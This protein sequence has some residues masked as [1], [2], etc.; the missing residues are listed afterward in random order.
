MENGA[1]TGVISI[2]VTFPAGFV[3]EDLIASLLDEKLIACANLLPEITSLYMWEG[4]M[5]CD[6]E[7]VAILKTSADRAETLTA[8]IRA[9]HPYEVPCIVAWPVIGGFTPYLEWVKT[10]T[11]A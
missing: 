1:E 2:Y 8:R 3:V 6:R 9:A 7:T 5:E 11:Q 4:R 10:Q